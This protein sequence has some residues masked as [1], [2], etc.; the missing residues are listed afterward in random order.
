M[1]G[2]GISENFVAFGFTF[3]AYVIVSKILSYVPS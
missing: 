3:F 1:S 2:P